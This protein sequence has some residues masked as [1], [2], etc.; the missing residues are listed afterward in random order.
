MSVNWSWKD[1]MGSVVLTQKHPKYESKDFDINIYAGNCLMIM[2]YEYKNEDGE[3]HYQMQAFFNDMAHLKRCIGLAKDY[4]G[5]Y[6]NMLSHEPNVYHTWKLNT[7]FKDSAK[8]AEQL[9]K[10]GYK[11]ELYYEKIE[12]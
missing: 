2:L 5:K 7:Y 10:A 12:G 1:K 4:E 3:E 9:T 6:D 8:I 11:V